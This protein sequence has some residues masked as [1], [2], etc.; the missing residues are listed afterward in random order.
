[1]GIPAQGKAARSGLRQ[2][3]TRIFLALR[4]QVFRQVVRITGS[5][6]EAEDI[7]QE[8]F[9][10]LYAELESGRSIANPRAW[11][12]RVA[13]NLA[14]DSY[15]AQRNLN[16]A[17]EGDTA[18]VPEMEDP[19]QQIEQSLLQREREVQISGLLRGLSAQERRC[20]ELRTEGLRYR[21]IAEI[22]GIRIGTIETNLSRAVKKLM[23]KV[24]V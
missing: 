7:T 9:L 4:D 15:R 8:A 6:A 19:S 24:D 14:I 21:E 1:L 3:V 23:E 5:P 2:E 22:L 12:F 20:I 16:T 10:R 17:D 18:R 13:C 11:L